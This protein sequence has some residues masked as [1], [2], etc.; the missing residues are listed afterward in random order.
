MGLPR[1]CRHCGAEQYQAAVDVSTAADA[2][3]RYLPGRW[4]ACP[5][6]GSTDEPISAP[7]PCLYAIPK[8]RGAQWIWAGPPAPFPDPPTPE[9]ILASAGLPVPLWW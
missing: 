5:A 6:C 2:H 1:I 7:T 4:E 9:Q 8:R 3:P